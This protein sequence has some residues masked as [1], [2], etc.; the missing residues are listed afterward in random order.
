MSTPSYARDLLE[1]FG[2][3]VEDI[4]TSDKEEKKE[5]D[6]I[7]S[8]GDVKVLIEEKTKNDDQSYLDTRTQELEQGRIHFRSIPL[9]RDNRLSGLV[10]DA[11]KQLRS[12]SNRVHDF[13]LMWFTSTGVSAEAKYKQF[14][15]SLY[16]QTSI[17]EMNGPLRRCYFFEN[18]DF[19]RR[20]SVIDGAVAAFVSDDSI[21]VKLCL[22]PLSAKYEALRRS[23]VVATFGNEVEDPRQSEANGTAFILDS[24]LDRTDEDPLLLYLQAKYGTKPLMRFDLGYTIAS[25]MFLIE[26]E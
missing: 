8:F 21:T 19:H 7:A 14:M 20:A 25:K 1:I 9:V 10:G 12:S 16:G 3:I 4:P 17:M 26:D 24:D 13:R 5:A 11:A 22:N 23:P 15:A 18:S 2:V 6:F